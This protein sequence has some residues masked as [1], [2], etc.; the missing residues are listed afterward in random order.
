MCQLTT[1][2]CPGGKS[3]APSTPFALSSSKG[4]RS[5]RTGASREPRGLSTVRGP[6]SNVFNLE[7]RTAAPRTASGGRFCLHRTIWLSDNPAGFGKKTSLFSKPQ[8]REGPAMPAGGDSPPGNP[9]HETGFVPPA[10]QQKPKLL[11]R[12]GETLCSH[13]YSPHTGQPYCHCVKRFIFFSPLR[14]L[15][16]ILRDDA[17]PGGG[18][19]HSYH[20]GAFW[21]QRCQD[22]VGVSG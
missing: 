8:C 4:E 6:M 11:D 12:S 10:E 22:H 1:V 14:N 2:R 7:H 21:A 18:V 5:L 3:R 20:S 19:R 13:H 9:R 15:S 17:P 16:R